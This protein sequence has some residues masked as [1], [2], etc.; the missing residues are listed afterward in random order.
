MSDEFDLAPPSEQQFQALVAD[1]GEEEKHV[2]LDHGTEAPFCGVFLD[3]NGRASSPAGCAAC[4]C[5]TAARSSK[6][7]PAG[8]A[9]PSRSRRII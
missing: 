6:A 5:S 1:L 9:S 4:R 2:L 3:E 7:A 8:R